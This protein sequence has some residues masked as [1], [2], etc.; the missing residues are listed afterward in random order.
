MPSSRG[1][2]R[3]RDRTLF[4]YVSCIAG[5]L[6]TTSSTHLCAYTQRLILSDWLTEVGKSY[7]CR[8]AGSLEI[9]AEP[10]LQFKSK[11]CSLLLLGGWSFV[12]PRFSTAQI[13]LSH[14]IIVEGSWHYSTSTH[15]NVNLILKSL[16]ETP[17]M[18]FDHI[19]GHCGPAKFMH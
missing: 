8:V 17:R 12:L 16:I 1:S 5:G 19:S 18:I 3:P 14:I 2:S 4:S 9:P 10:M 7:T 6:F 13:R 15:L 11:A